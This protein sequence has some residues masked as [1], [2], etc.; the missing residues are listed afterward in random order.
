M[1]NLTSLKELGA[2]KHLIK[3]NAS[4]NNLKQTFDF[5]PP[6]NLEWV[7]YSGNKISRITGA[8]NNIYL[9]YLHLDNN[10]IKQISGLES[11]KCLRLLS[12]GGN[13][14]QRIENLNNMWLE[15]LYLMANE[16]TII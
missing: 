16:I 11:N 8:E 1:N 15:E 3:L 14:I 13:H 7:D 12:L 5:S 10:D 4:N 2:I 6:A 9:K